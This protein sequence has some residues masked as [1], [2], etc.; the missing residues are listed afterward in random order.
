MRQQVSTDP[1]MSWKIL[2]RVETFEKS[3]YFPITYHLSHHLALQHVFNV[4]G[5]CLESSHLKYLLHHEWQQVWTYWIHRYLG[6]FE[7]VICSMCNS[8]R[9]ETELQTCSGHVEATWKD[10]YLNWLNLF[11]YQVGL[12]ELCVLCQ[13]VQSQRA[14]SFISRVITVTYDTITLIPTRRKWPNLIIL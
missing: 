14:L 11:A 1:D 3:T 10:S 8:Q 4:T 6:S 5:S 9:L 2:P 7:N 13:L 12:S